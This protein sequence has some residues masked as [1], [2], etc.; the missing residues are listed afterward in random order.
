MFDRKVTMSGVVSP[1]ETLSSGVVTPSVP[2]LGRALAAHAPDLARHLDG[3]S[4]A[5]GAGDRDDGF[6]HRA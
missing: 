2:M 3:R 6:G 4:L 1:V 5:V